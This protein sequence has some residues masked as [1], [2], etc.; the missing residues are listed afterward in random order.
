MVRTKCLAHMYVWW[1]GMNGDI[2]CL[3]Q[4]CWSCQKTQTQLPETPLHSW[5][6]PSRPWARLHLDY[7]GPVEEKM[8]LVMVDTHSKWIEAIH[9]SIATSEKVIEACHERLS[10]FGL[11]ETIVT[12]NGTCFVSSE[13]EAFSWGMASN[14]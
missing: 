7:T 9:T 13:F 6:W 8:V 3:V 12:D 11:P 4:Q 10:Q 2:D 14:T 5:S 1:P